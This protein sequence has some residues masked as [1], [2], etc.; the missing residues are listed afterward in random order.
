MVQVGSIWDLTQLAI[1][2]FFLLFDLSFMEADGKSHFT[3]Y[4]SIYAKNKAL[5]GSQILRQYDF[6][7]KKIFKNNINSQ[8]MFPTNIY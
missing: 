2:Q 1:R 4:F 5:D 6:L 8:R 7:S 3:L